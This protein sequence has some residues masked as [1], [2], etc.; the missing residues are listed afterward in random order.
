M[1]YLGQRPSK[2]DE[3]NFKILDNISSYTLTFD[4]SDATVVSA[5]NDT[6]TSLTHRFVQGQRVT[7]NKGGGTVIPGL[8]DGVYYIIKNDH[9]TIKL[10]T[11]ASNASN[12]VAVNITGVGG[13]SSHT[14]NV[15]FDGVNTK[16]KATHTNGQ[17]AKITRSAQLVISINGV[18]QQPHDSAT[19]STGFG[20]DL[21]GTIIFSQAPVS[22]DAY[23]AHVLTN[24]NVTFDISD[25]DIDNF[26]GN[27]STVSFNLSKSP[28]DNRNIL[29]T[30]DGVVQYPNDPDGTVRSY[31]V[32]E[33]VLTFTTAPASGVEIQV[34]HIGF[35]GSTSGG[36]SGGVTSFYGRTGAVVLKSTDNVTV[37]DAAITGDATV[38]GNLTV[39]GT[40]T[41]LDTIL[42]EVDKLEVAANN[43]TVGV[44]VTQSGS[45]DILN[46]YDGSTEVFSVADG[47]NIDI[48]A[49]SVTLIKS[50]GPLLE[51]T[52]NT[53]AADATLRLSEGSAGSTTN[54][55]GMFYSGADN[56][57]HITCGANSTTK[58]ITINR[59]NGI[60]GIN[61]TSPAGAQLVIKNSDDSNLNAISI[62]NDNGNMSSSLSQDSSGAGSYL[63]KDN[64]GNIKTFI[65]SYS[66]SYFLGGDIGIGNNSPNCK[67]A[68]K[69]TAEH[70]AY[71]NVTPSVTECMLQLYNNPPNETANDHA[72]MQFGVNGGSHN[73]VNTI[74][75]VAESAGNRKLAF[76]FCTDEAGS[77]TEKLRITGDGKIGIG[78]VSPD[79]NLELFKESG[80]NLVKVSTEANSTVGFE[81]EKTGSTTQ[82]WRIVD[83]QTA[84]GAL[85]F[86]DVTDDETRLMIDTAGRILINRTAQHASSSERL[87]VN[88]MTSIQYNSTTTAGL[89]IF[90]EET[91]TSGNPIQPFI[92]CSDGSGLRAGL[93]VQR[94]TGVTVLNGQFGLSFRTGSSGVGGSEKLRIGTNGNVII[95]TDTWQYEKPLNV[96]GSSGSILSLYNADTTTYAADTNSSIELKLLTGNTGNQFG[97][98]EIRGIKENGTN[99]D[100]ARALSFWTGVNGGSNVERIRI[101]SS[102][103]IQ[104]NGATGKSTSGTSATDLLLANGAAIRFRRAN[105]SNWINTIGIDSSDNLKLGWGGSVDEIHFGIAGIGDQMK[106]DSSGR[107]LLGV[108]ASST[109]AFT[110]GDDLIIG[111]TSSTRSGIT[112]VSSSD[113]DGGLYFS[114]GTS[115][116]NDN[117][118]GQIVY[119]HP[120]DYLQF[121]TSNS[122]RMRIDTNEL[123]FDST[124]QQIHL[125][126]SDGS[127]TGYLN[128]GAAGGPNNQNR[129]AQAV[130]YGN[131]NSSYAGQCGLLAGNSGS[132]QGYIYFN[133]GGDTRVRIESDGEIEFTTAGYKFTENN[134][135][136]TS[137]ATVNDA[138]AQHTNAMTSLMGS[139]HSTNNTDG[140]ID[141][142]DY[143][144][145]DWT[146]LE[147]YGRVNP[148]RG[149]SGAYQDLFYMT[150]YK[151]IG[152]TYPNVVTTIF[153]VMHTPA[154]RTMYSSGTSSSGND[155][156]TAV[157]YNGSSES[158]EFTYNNSNM[159]A[160]YLRI[161]VPTSSF[162]T[163]HGC[164]FSARIFKRF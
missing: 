33:N 144:A 88:G 66:S 163:T 76:T 74:S 79:Q 81:I 70:T 39:N 12:G 147:V 35:A 154:A 10:A 151:G 159:A 26:T 14:L 97:T 135:L 63:Q 111:H 15:A 38:T 11:S 143:K 4:G 80:T 96:Q 8:S 162:N 75:A 93:G 7:Y 153:A 164:G 58:R 78:T 30:L 138:T 72:T 145:S 94:S 51:L 142:T 118:K 155:G 130:F 17:K 25:N 67:L 119:N 89:Y 139:Y 121:Y 149:G 84:N 6:I 123:R 136:S 45:G 146:I 87:S 157:W 54:G 115:T 109:Y 131:E 105:D 36:G 55:G 98:L 3:N 18:I 103:Q 37:N 85:E 48:N 77:R 46:L 133:T 43:S 50:S 86:Y 65:R 110:G 47:G 28:P 68:I 59:D 104:L 125:N 40:T 64:A 71:A 44:A 112:L 126:T 69:D 132:N 62:F 16:F 158:R 82:T 161:K 61:S 107:I 152:Y 53:G 56:K 95:G 52:T 160:N 116:N 102:G 41:T 90:N 13:G 24:N 140:I 34:R 101:T 148:N 2:G 120:G 9:N 49:G 99:G 106:L 57:L 22:T 128:I 124:A 122:P 29:V 19:P 83:G 20:F 127:D 1:P 100:N 117:V 129:G 92:F 31:T 156:I 134:F 73:R 91:T 23:W 137:A 5:A 21:D 150:I 113:N 108:N 27:G 42:T 32:V 141:L 114:R 60:V